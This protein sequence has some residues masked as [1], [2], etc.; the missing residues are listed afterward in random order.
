M[1][2]LEEELFVS[3]QINRLVEL[4]PKWSSETAAAAGAAASAVS[5]A[6][7]WQRKFVKAAE[8][9]RKQKLHENPPVPHSLCL[10]HAELSREWASGRRRKKRI[11]NDFAARFGLFRPFLHLSLGNS[12]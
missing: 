11:S 2:T 5:A 9:E 12:E 8:G 10:S 6:A 1:A 7:L 3:I 4:C